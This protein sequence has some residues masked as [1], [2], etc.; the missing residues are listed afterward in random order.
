MADLEKAIS[1]KT[2]A[3]FLAHT[4]GNP[5]DLDIV[6]EIAEKHELWV[7]EDNCDALGSTWRG[8]LTGT[9][10]DLST[11]SFYPAHHITLGEGGAVNT[12]KPK[13]KKIAELCAEKVYEAGDQIFSYGASP[14]HPGTEKGYYTGKMTRGVGFGGLVSAD[15]AGGLGLLNLIDDILDII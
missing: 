13:L 3:I 15:R 1:N 10:G 14:R 12:D 2:K 6:M 11:Q 4:L 9:F 7:I 8:K 5:F